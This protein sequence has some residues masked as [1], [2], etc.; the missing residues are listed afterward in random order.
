MGE[1]NKKCQGRQASKTVEF[2]D[3]ILIV[4]YTECDG[5]TTI[6]FKKKRK[7]EIQELVTELIRTPLHRSKEPP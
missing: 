4:N 7:H 5:R 2:R 6:T 3:F 1:G